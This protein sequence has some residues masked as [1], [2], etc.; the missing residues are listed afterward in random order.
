MCSTVRPSAHACCAPRSAADW[1]G[2]LWRRRGARSFPPPGG[3]RG[4]ALGSAD[5]R[6]MCGLGLQI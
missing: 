2:L 5:M 4:R 1:F 3:S 6:Q